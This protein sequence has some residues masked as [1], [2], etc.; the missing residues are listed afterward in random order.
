MI[1]IHPSEIPTIEALGGM[2]KGGLLQPRAGEHK[3]PFKTT[4]DLCGLHETPDKPFGCIASPFT[5]NAKN[6]LIVRNRYRLLKCYNDGRKIPAYLAFNASLRLIFGVDLAADITAHFD[7]NGGDIVVDMPYHSYMML[8]EN[9]DIKHGRVSNADPLTPRW[10]TGNSL[11]LDTLLPDDTFDLVFTCPPYY[12][13]EI[14]SDDDNDL[15]NYDSY[16]SFIADYRAIIAASIARLND[17]RFA[18]VVVG[19]IRDKRGVYRNFVS[20]TIAAFQDAGALLYNEAIL[21]TSVGSLPIRVGKQFTAGRKLGK[22]HQNVQVFIKGDSKIATE[23]CG[24]I[25]IHLEDTPELTN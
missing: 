8:T 14:Y 25:D 23:Y 2:V 7:N 10:I 15:S 11:E 22:T 20:D 9:D 19:D 17:N 3:C 21:V 6:T 4:A 18:A 1:T 13:L 16:E 5:L 12:D 24:D